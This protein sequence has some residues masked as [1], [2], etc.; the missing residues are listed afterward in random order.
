MTPLGHTLGGS[1]AEADAPVCG[2]GTRGFETRLSPQ[3]IWLA[4]LLE[5]EGSFGLWSNGN[6]G[7]KLKVSVQMTDFDVVHRV[8]DMWGTS[9]AHIKPQKAHHKPSFRTQ[10]GGDRAAELMNR[11]RPLMGERRTEQIDRVLRERAPK[12]TEVTGALAI[13]IVA[14]VKAGNESVPAIAARFGIRR[15]SVYRI[16]RRSNASVHPMHVVDVGSSSGP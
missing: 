7:F 3:D 15:E 12:R 16:V 2:T 4:G 5:G 8:A 14:A 6:G 13:E 9:I 1:S 10:L 11:I